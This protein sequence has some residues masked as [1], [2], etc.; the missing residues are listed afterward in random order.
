MDG[1]SRA[2]SVD[3]AP[4]ASSSRNHSQVYHAISPIH[5]YLKLFNGWKFTAADN[6][7][8][9]DEVAVEW[10]EKVFPPRTTKLG[11][12]RR[13]LIFNGH[14]EPRLRSTATGLITVVA[15]PRE[16]NFV[17]FAGFHRNEGYAL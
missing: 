3:S 15:Q 16:V 6:G 14:G 1:V 8:T 7:W 10:L 13:L 12:G 2:S 5:P 4:S 11:Q 17:A 9:S